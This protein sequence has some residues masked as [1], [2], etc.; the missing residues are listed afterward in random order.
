[1]RPAKSTGG[2][3]KFEQAQPGEYLGLVCG[4]YDLGTQPA[5]MYDAAHKLM[6]EWALWW[7]DRDREQWVE[8]RTTDGHQH[9]KVMTFTYSWGEK[10]NFR[11]VALTMVPTTFASESSIDPEILLGK[12]CWIE[13][14]EKKDKKTG[15]VFANISTNGIT[16]F[17]ERDGQIPKTDRNFVVYELDTEQGI[18]DNVPKFIQKKIR[19]SHEWVA[20]HGKGSNQAPK[21]NPATP[22]GTTS[23]PGRPGASASAPSRPPGSNGTATA[24][25]TRPSAPR[26]SPMNPTAVDEDDDIPF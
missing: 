25:A 22:P 12:P 19:E 15:E 16:R 14:V 20:V 8:A 26:S 10:A 21:A 9:T 18:P 4:I 3:E 7:W 2:G 23:R 5:D 24:T 13:L 17:K 6:L 11:A 1:M